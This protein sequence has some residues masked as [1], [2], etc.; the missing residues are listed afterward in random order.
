MKYAKYL[1]IPDWK[2]LQSQLIDF[3][4][5]HSN[6]E[7]M[8]WSHGG[9]DVEKYLPDLYNAFKSMGLT[10]RQMIFFTNLN[11]D[12]EINDPLDPRAVFIHTDKIDNPKARYDYAMPV[13]TDFEPTNAINIPMLNCDGSTTL[14]YELIDKDQEDVYY[15]VIG[16]GGIAK[17]NTKEVYRF[18]LNQPSVIRINIP[19]AVW[20]PNAGPRVVATFR[21]VESTDHLLE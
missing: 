5:Q 8:W 21:F 9:D 12:I 14:F 4:E 3:R 2:K 18:E 1:D 17:T 6:K 20:N 16:C 15:T 7:A 10:A 13:F 19:H 11:N